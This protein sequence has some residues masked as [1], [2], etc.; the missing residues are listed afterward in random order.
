MHAYFNYEKISYTMYLF[1]HLE[2]LTSSW[3]AKSLPIRIKNHH[4]CQT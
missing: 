1:L 2:S 4:N 3:L